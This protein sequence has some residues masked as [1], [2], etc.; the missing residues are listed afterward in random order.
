MTGVRRAGHGVSRQ[1]NADD[2]PWQRNGNLDDVGNGPVIVHVMRRVGLGKAHVM[3]LSV[4]TSA[5]PA[6]IGWSFSAAECEFVLQ[7]HWFS[8]SPASP[9][10]WVLNSCSSQC[11]RS[12]TGRRRSFCF[13]AAWRSRERGRPQPADRTT[14]AR[15]VRQC[16]LARSLSA[17]RR[18]MLHTRE[19]W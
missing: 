15:V 7:A 10:I 8:C 3:G 12:G 13:R 16:R 1:L 9:D 2:E 14:L 17:S 5:V 11:K 19:A 6:T 4:P 18:A